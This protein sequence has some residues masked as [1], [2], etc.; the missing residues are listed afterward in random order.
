MYD[1][2]K[3]FGVCQNCTDNTEG[4]MCERCKTN[5]YVDPKKNFDDP[6]SC[7]GKSV[8]VVYIYIPCRKS[9]ETGHN[10]MRSLSIS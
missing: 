2:G 7:I 3:G 1:E 5:F 10:L 8:S 9:H 6:G 4:D